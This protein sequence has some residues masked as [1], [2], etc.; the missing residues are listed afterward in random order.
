MKK[1]NPKY[2]DVLFKLF[3]SLVMT[4]IMSVVITLTNI[5]FKPDFFYKWP[6]AYAV[7]FVISFPSILIAV[8]VAKRIV[9]RLTG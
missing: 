5:G 2:A 1:I 6:M 9:K 7:G 4:T 8:P 3:L